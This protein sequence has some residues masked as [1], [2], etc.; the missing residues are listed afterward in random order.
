MVMSIPSLKP[1]D[2]VMVSPELSPTSAYTSTKKPQLLS[3]PATKNLQTSATLSPFIVE[4]PYQLSKS[5]SLQASQVFGELVYTTHAEDGF[6]LTK[7]EKQV[8]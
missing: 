1:S 4:V 8:F 3:P 2:D 6:T 7:P 5:P